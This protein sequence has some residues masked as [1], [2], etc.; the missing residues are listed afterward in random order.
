MK[1]SKTFFVVSALMSGI[2]VQA[3]VTGGTSESVS[4]SR[5]NRRLGLIV[6]VGSP[7]PGL[8]GANVAYNVLSALRAEVGLAQIKTEFFG[9]ETSSTTFGFGAK[10]FVP[11]WK[12]TPTVGLHFATYT[13]S[14]SGEFIGSSSSG[15]SHIYTTLGMDYQ[16]TS[17][18][19]LGVGYAVSFRS[20]MGSSAFI[21]LGWFFDWIG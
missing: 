7:S 6:G 19:N 12:L 10:G 18:F 17:G 13:N 11:G 5:M 1:I 8:V 21:N 16:A 20:G 14:T 15:G 4:E 9:Q 3:A 2:A